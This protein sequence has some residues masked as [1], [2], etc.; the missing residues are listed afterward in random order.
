EGL[1]ARPAGVGTRSPRRG[2]GRRA[3]RGG[4]GSHEPVPEESGQAGPA[5]GPDEPGPEDGG[6]GGRAARARRHA[7]APRRAPMPAQT[8]VTA[9]AIIGPTAATPRAPRAARRGS[10][11]LVRAQGR[12]QPKAAQPRPARTAQRPARAST[13]G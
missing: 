10:W 13:R 8:R 9:G 6:A 11:T 2:D 5:P 12:A 7:R 4:T 1:V 3:G